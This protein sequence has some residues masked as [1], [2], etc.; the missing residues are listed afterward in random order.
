MH[1]SPVPTYTT[2]GSE[3]ATS[4]APIEETASLSNRLA[5]EAPPLVVFQTPPPVYPA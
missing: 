1:A 5:Q 4:I 3:S 2:F